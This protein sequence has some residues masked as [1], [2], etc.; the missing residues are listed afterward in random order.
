MNH[1]QCRQEHP[2]D[3]FFKDK[4]KAGCLKR[5]FGSGDFELS[6][7]SKAELFTTANDH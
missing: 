6:F 2:G 7:Q 4:I 5:G 1:I 3:F